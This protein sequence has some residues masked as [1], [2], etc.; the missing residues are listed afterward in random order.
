MADVIPPTGLQ[1]TPTA[2]GNQAKA[3]LRIWIAAIG[4]ALVTAAANKLHL[5][6]LTAL[7]GA[8]GDQIVG[9]VVGS[10]ML[11]LMSGWQWA[12][13]RLVNSR[14]WK[15]ATDDRVPNDLVRPATS[16]PPHTDAA[17]LAAKLKQEN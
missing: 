8:Q 7:W 3:Q 10:L 6:I 14:W 2:I 17:D 1:I 15:L 4:G 13:V 5:P 9:L 12:R 16:M 11:A